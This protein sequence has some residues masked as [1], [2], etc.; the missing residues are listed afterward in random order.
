MKLLTLNSHSWQEDNQ[1]DKMNH[2]AEVIKEEAFDIIALQ[3][4]SQH[5]LGKHFEDNL[6]TDNYMVLLEGALARIG[7]PHYERFWD[8]AHIG[9]EVYEEGLCLLSKHP[10]VEK[11]SFF[12]SMSHD[13]LYW[14]TRKIVRITIDYHGELID[15]YSCHLGW[16]G[17]ADEPFKAQIDSLS[18]KLHP[19]RRA[20]ML[21]DFN[22][23]AN[24]SGEGYD[25]M[26]HTLGWLDTYELA[27]SK[28]E[29]ITVKGE[30]HGWEANQKALR[31]DLIF[32]NQPAK[33]AYSKTIFNGT[34][35]E[36]ISDHY[37]VM[38][39]LEG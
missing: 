9:F 37:G 5:M 23:N 24:V 31:L 20:F 7:A 33:V 29:G 35:K 8:F 11:D 30:I 21:G 14:K 18:Q 27:K 32:T 2:L 6:N 34:N 17:D 1:L 16:W 3:E 26:K 13:T 38:I 19:T 12:V 36:V 4:V 39:E 28:D 15:F 25:Y 22:N 10:I